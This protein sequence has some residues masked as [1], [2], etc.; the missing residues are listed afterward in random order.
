MALI[1]DG[2][3]VGP[4]PSSASRST[5]LFPSTLVLLPDQSHSRSP[6]SA[7]RLRSQ[8]TAAVCRSRC[9]SPDFADIWPQS[10]PPPPTPRRIHVVRRMVR[11]GSQLMSTWQSVRARSAAFSSE[12]LHQHIPRCVT[13]L[14]S[15]PS[16]TNAGVPISHPQRPPTGCRTPNTCR[17][18]N[19]M[20]AVVAATA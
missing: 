18:E 20:R 11:S 13:Q 6:C 9:R 5:T 1:A 10:R 15:N 7:T 3:L 17:S 2:F 16:S 14:C 12:P 4:R 19:T 8:M